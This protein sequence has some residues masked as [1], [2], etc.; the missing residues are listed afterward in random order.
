MRILLDS[1]ST[2]LF[3]VEVARKV[4][5][6][7]AIVLGYIKDR[8]EHKGLEYEGRCWLYKK[9]KNIKEDLK[10]LSHKSINN[11]INKLHRKGIIEISYSL[12]GNHLDRTRYMRPLESNYD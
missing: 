11:A 1:D 12:D 6:K 2:I 10:F 3:D 8:I 5:L 7:E 4:G 9:A